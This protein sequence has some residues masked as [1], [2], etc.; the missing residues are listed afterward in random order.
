MIADEQERDG[1]FIPLEQDA[2]GQI[3]AKFPYRPSH[4]FNAKT[5]RQ[6]PGIKG[7]DEC[8]DI[9]LNFHPFCRM[10]TPQDSFAASAEKIPQ[11]K[12]PKMLEESRR[13]LE[14][15]ITP[16]SLGIGRHSLYLAFGKSR[17]IR[18]VYGLSHELGIALPGLGR[19]SPK[20]QNLF[21][22]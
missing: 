4:F 16:S 20:G 6:I 17:R 13:I 18:T 10:A 8:I 1:L 7:P 5:N 9:S 22:L 11:S 2:R 3:Y 15:L 14:F 21:F 19:F 12:A